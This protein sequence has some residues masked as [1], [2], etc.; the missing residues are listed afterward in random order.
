MYGKST[1][2]Y[3]YTDTLGNQ[4]TTTKTSWYGPNKNANS[5]KI[6]TKYKCDE[7][8]K[9]VNKHNVEIPWNHSRSN[10]HTDPWNEKVTNQSTGWVKN[11]LSSSS[12]W[13]VTKNEGNKIVEC[14]DIDMSGDDNTNSTQPTF[15]SGLDSN[16][17]YPTTVNYAAMPRDEMDSTVIKRTD[18]PREVAAINIRTQNGSLQPDDCGLE[19][20]KIQ[21]STSNHDTDMMQQIHIKTRAFFQESLEN[22]EKAKN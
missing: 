9:Y 12:K 2:A 4:S 21:K 22:L 13:G 17:V 1:P 8:K 7:S 3:K 20:K 10:P 18:P 5:S 19:Y 6:N 16:P 11:D 15:A 14:I